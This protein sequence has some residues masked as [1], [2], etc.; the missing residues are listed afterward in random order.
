MVT[1]YFF[2]KDFQSFWL[3]HCDIGRGIVD[4]F[5]SMCACAMV[6][7]ISRTIDIKNEKD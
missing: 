3:V 1:W 7:L 6:I 5:G 2:I 4:I